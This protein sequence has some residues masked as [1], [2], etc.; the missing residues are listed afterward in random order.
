MTTAK[1]SSV[2]EFRGIYILY[3]ALVAGQVLIA[4]IMSY[5]LFDAVKIFSWEMSNPFH[6]IAPILML[7]CI[8]VSSFLFTKKM[9]EAKS[10]KGLSAK[11]E[12][13]RMFNYFAK[14][15]IGGGKL[16]LYYFLL[17]RAKLFLL[18]FIF[19]WFSCISAYQTFKRN[20]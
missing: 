19:Y 7:S 12:H 18:T 9:E 14:F 15:V 20:V 3:Y 17:F 2:N 6:L 10:I 13:Y 16:G 8:S 1:N 4:L 5:E 11:L